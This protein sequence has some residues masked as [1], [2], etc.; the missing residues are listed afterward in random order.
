LN[1]NKAEGR[2]ASSRAIYTVH[3]PEWK[4]NVGLSVASRAEKVNREFLL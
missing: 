3:K 1:C 4:E 2:D